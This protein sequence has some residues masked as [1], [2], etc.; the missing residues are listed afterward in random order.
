MKI[1]LISAALVVA[2]TTPAFA[3]HCPKDVAIIDQSLSKSMG[4]GKMDMKGM[5]SDKMSMMM[6]AKTLPDRGA[7]EHKSGNHG[8]SIKTLHEAIKMLGLKPFKTM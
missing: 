2:M 5:G 6:K 3:K 8:A 1:V 7:A 4:S